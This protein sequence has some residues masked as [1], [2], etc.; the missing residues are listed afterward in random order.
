MAILITGAILLSMGAAVSVSADENAA[1]HSI[2]VVEG[3]PQEPHCC[4]SDNTAIAGER[5]GLMHNDGIYTPTPPHQLLYTFTRWVVHYPAGLVIERDSSGFFFI[6]PN[7]AVRIEALFENRVGEP[8]ST[9]PAP[10]TTNAP[11]ATNAPLAATTPA[12]P[13]DD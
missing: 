1:R 9:T 4:C 2:E 6:M 5:V 8:P 13:N 7:E 11:S 3:R 12:P 10:P